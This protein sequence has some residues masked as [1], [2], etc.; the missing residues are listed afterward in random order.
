MR[1]TFDFETL[2]IEESSDFESELDFVISE[3]SNE[4]RQLLLSADDLPDCIYEAIVRSIS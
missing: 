3:I 2:K 1:K 4:D